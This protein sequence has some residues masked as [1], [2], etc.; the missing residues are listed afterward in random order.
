MHQILTIL[1][2]YAFLKTPPFSMIS[3]IQVLGQRP[4]I[5]SSFSRQVKF[6]SKNYFN[7]QLYRTDTF[8]SEHRILEDTF[9]PCS[10]LSFPRHHVCFFKIPPRLQNLVPYLLYRREYHLIVQES[11]RCTRHQPRLPIH[12]IRHIYHARSSQIRTTVYICV[13]LGWVYHQ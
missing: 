7:L 8:L 9:L 2:G 10:Q 13:F 5:T 12:T 6:H 1:D 4:R 3:R 11:L